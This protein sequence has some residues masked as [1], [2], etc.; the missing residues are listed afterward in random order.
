MS[1]VLTRDKPKQA[2]SFHHPFLGE[3]IKQIRLRDTLGKYSNYSDELVINQFIIPK[4]QAEILE[5]ILSFQA[6]DQLLVD[7]FYN[8]IGVSIE[9]KSGYATETF[10]HFKSKEF[11]SAVICCGGVLVLCS[12]IFGARNC[13][14][15]S[16]PELIESAETSIKYSLAKASRYLDFVYCSESK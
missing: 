11:S 13:G 15:I 9:K 10:V 16:L 12:L 5:R 4:N 3:L 7:A 8:A 14:F 1:Q 6:I 2:P